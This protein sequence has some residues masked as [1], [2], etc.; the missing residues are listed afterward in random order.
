MSLLGVHWAVDLGDELGLA[1]ATS[2]AKHAVHRLIRDS[3]GVVDWLVSCRTDYVLVPSQPPR[4]MFECTKVMSARKK[5]IPVITFAFFEA[6]VAAGAVLSTD[7][8]IADF[9]S[10]VSSSASCEA[11][12][13]TLVTSPRA[14]LLQP[15]T[16]SV[17]D[18]ISTEYKF[19]LD[20]AEQDGHP[21]FPGPFAVAKVHLFT[22]PLDQG[23]RFRVIELH[24]AGT[25]TG[26]RQ[27]RVVRHEGTRGRTHEDQPAVAEYPATLR[28]AEARYADW[29]A[30]SRGWD[31]PALAELSVGSRAARALAMGPCVKRLAA[32]MDPELQSLI[33]E[34][35]AEAWGRLRRSTWREVVPEHAQ[36]AL[37]S[38]TLVEVAKA[39]AM[40]HQLRHRARVSRVTTFNFLQLWDILQPTTA[41]PEDSEDPEHQG[42]LWDLQD[43]CEALRDLLTV[44]E[45]ACGNVYNA[46]VA[47]QYGALGCHLRPLSPDSVAY[48]AI[49]EAVAQD[50]GPVKAVRGVYSVHKYSEHMGLREPLGNAALL[51]HG[52]PIGNWVGI[53]SRGLQVPKFEHRRR[54]LGMLGCGIYFAP[55]PSTACRYT[56]PGRRG[57]CF[58]AVCRVLLGRC[59]DV[60]TMQPGWTQPPPSYD[61]VHAIPGADFE[62]D[63]YVVYDAAQQALV[64][65]VEVELANP[66]ACLP[67]PSGPVPGQYV[68]QSLSAPATVGDISMP[69]KLTAVGRIGLV[70]DGAVCAPLQGVHVK[71][72]LMDLIAEV[73][74]FQQYKSPLGVPIEAKYV[75]PLQKGCV[76]CGFE[77]YIGAKHV[78]G[79][80]REKEEARREYHEAV[81]KG[82]GAYLMEEESEM[83]ET[84]TVAVG[85]LPSHAEVVVQITYLLELQME[86]ETNQIVFTFPA[87]TLPRVEDAALQI[88]TQTTTDS[89]AGRLADVAVFALEVGAVM[90]YDIL[91]VWC[92][93]AVARKQTQTCLM[94]KLQDTQKPPDADI[95][96]RLKME[97]PSAP[98]LWVETNNKGHQAAMLTVYPSTEDLQPFAPVDVEVLLVLDM[99]CS[100]AQGDAFTDLQRVVYQV[101]KLLPPR[102][103]FQVIGFGSVHQSLFATSQP[104][105]ELHVSEAVDYLCAAQPIWGGSCLSPVLQGVYSLADPTRPPRSIFL[106]SDGDLSDGAAALA[107]V[108]ANRVH[109]RLFTFGVGACNSHF[110]QLLAA[111]GGGKAAVMPHKQPSTWASLVEAQVRR[112]GQSSFVNM[113]V[114]WSGSTNAFARQEFSAHIQ[115]APRYPPPVFAGEQA[116]AYAF[117]ER[118]VRRAELTCIAIR[119]DGDVVQEVPVNTFIETRPAT[120]TRGQIVHRLTAMKLIRDWQ[121]GLL[122]LERSEDDCIRDQLKQQMIELGCEYGIVT[123]YTSMFAVEER[124]S[125]LLE[126]MPKDQVRHFN[127]LVSAVVVDPIPDLGFEAVQQGGVVDQHQSREPTFHAAVAE[128][129]HG[130][131]QMRVPLDEDNQ[132]EECAWACEEGV[133]SWMDGLR[134]VDEEAKYGECHRLEDGVRPSWMDGLHCVDEEAQHAAIREQV[135]SVLATVGVEEIEGTTLWGEA[136]LDSLA[137]VEMRNGLSRVLGNTMTLGHAALFDYPTLD[138]LQQHVARTLF[139][140]EECRR[141]VAMPVEMQPMAIV[142]MACRF[143]GRC[144]SAEEFWRFLEDRGDGAGEIPLT[145]MD[146]RT[147][148]DPEQS[149]GKSYTNRG[150]FIEGVTMFDHKRFR[151]SAAEAVMVM[152][153]QRI[154]LETVYQAFCQS[155]INV[156]ESSG[157]PIGTFMA[158]APA[159]F[160]SSETQDVLLSPYAATGAALSITAN[161]LA[162]VFGLVGPSMAI[163]TACSSSLVATDAACKAMYAHDCEVAVAVGVNLFFNFEVFISCCAAGMLSRKG[164]CATFSDDADGYLRGEGCGAVVLKL[165]SNALSARDKMWGV[166]HGTAVNQ[167]GRT[168]TLT[169]SNGPS[170]ESVIRTAIERAGVLANE[171]G[172][173]E[174]HGTGTPLGDPQE[175]GALAHVFGRGRESPLVVGAA[176]TNV[177]HLE[178]AAGMVGLIK[179][180]LCVQRGRV[181]PNIHCRAMN[182]RVMESVGQCHIAFPSRSDVLAVR[183]AG[184]SS[185]GF[186]GTNAHVVMGVPSEGSVSPLEPVIAWQREVFPWH[187][188]AHP[189]LG[190]SERSEH[191]C[192]WTC[193]WDAEIVEYLSDHRVRDVAVVPGTCY[194]EMVAAAVE[195]MFGNVPYEL[196]DIRFLRYALLD[197]GSPPTVRLSM[198]ADSAETEASGEWEITIGSMQPGDWAWTLHVKMRLCLGQPM[199]CPIDVQETIA[200]CD[201]RVECGEA[202]YETLGNAYR[203]DFRS[204]KMVWLG[205]REWIG[206]IEPIAGRS[207]APTFLRTCALLDCA[208][209]VGMVRLDVVDRMAGLYAAEVGACYVTGTRRRGLQKLWGHVKMEDD[210]ERTR[211]GMYDEDGKMLMQMTGLKGGQFATELLPAQGWLEVLRTADAAARRQSIRAHVASVFSRGGCQGLTGTTAFV[212]AG[213][214]P[215]A[216]TTAF[217]E[218]GMD[219]LAT[220]DVCNALSLV[221][222]PSAGLSGTVLFDHPTLDALLEHI[223]ATLFPEG[224]PVAVI[225]EPSAKQAAAPAP[226]P[227][228]SADDALVAPFKDLDSVPEEAYQFTAATEYRALQARLAALEA[229][230]PPILFRSHEAVSKSTAIVD[231]RVLSFSS[232]AC[233]IPPFHSDPTL[234]T[235][236]SK[237]ASATRM[238][239]GTRPS[240]TPHN[241]PPFSDHF[242]KF[243][244]FPRGN[245]V[246]GGWVGGLAAVG[247]DPR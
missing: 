146:W 65:L 231:G 171:I 104:R 100:M 19:D 91:D 89:V 242:N 22:K 179:T 189:L 245:D 53:L 94:L 39:E 204:L 77:A 123:P 80:V 116:I 220:V 168:A 121:N 211:V 175:V 113:Q 66:D 169:A 76:V 95:V 144:N 49:A 57:T 186:G 198:S 47:V 208:T 68:S 236:A 173:L 152:P 239:S 201:E 79:V 241:R 114:D 128:Q 3:G 30:Q 134:D 126:G 119:R 52:S 155:N 27:Y 31:R 157:L 221:F 51:Y 93:H 9:G 55:R 13:Q 70:C 223:E 69:P 131:L 210:G 191:G 160:T 85:N 2:K 138:A 117:A 10:E 192:V 60:H 111:E 187:T 115:P 182:P 44:G 88:A 75:F 81:A 148:Y 102:S 96:V 108:R 6:C 133:T 212:E 159:D 178:V 149:V 228:P 154:A 90:P 26:T 46:P 246:G 226:E 156:E 214:D 56:L 196:V 176:K 218:A 222:G 167:D 99:S 215:L 190:A 227:A 118:H 48:A 177:G 28:A 63:E 72:R 15:P 142:G 106:F 183:Y 11:S 235:P 233:P 16:Q 163:D 153:E 50:P 140:S 25:V 130:K 4:A 224:G 82:H 150:A 97:S 86:P 43:L 20:A 136:G 110:L 147:W 240:P 137:M 12:P 225:A 174:A 145:R 217:V 14:P 184:V 194:L 180:A 158:A 164:R 54:D 67:L 200:R 125:A 45:A 207:Q 78:V 166:V 185:F 216:G 38:L 107:L 247:R 162:Y 83:P 87:A 237:P 32:P 112:A 205:L 18:D 37:G 33:E 213:I 203:G 143:P 202:F 40:L 229:M 161:R 21:P 42:L 71:A 124:D 23:L 105:T 234:R 193:D 206:E 170:Q 188:L 172:Y 199:P 232:G 197:A 34:L 127:R 84:F 139:G 7:G 141:A 29:A 243:D 1:N 165:L 17:G 209:H 36:N 244:L 219:P 101:L 8:Y 59:R 230:G 5:G 58:L 73:V 74:V 64:Y 109:T 35:Y 151:I 103:R 195:E 122:S 135:M 62:D 120:E 24:V 132:E 181:P 238:P 98:R 41:L 92:S 61:S 129:G